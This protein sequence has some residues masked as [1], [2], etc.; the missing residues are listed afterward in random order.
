MNI[1]TKVLVVDDEPSI[2]KFLKAS[3]TMQDYQVLEA[4]TATE[5]LHI[6][7][8]ETP[9]LIVLD[10][11]LPD[12][13]G[14]TVLTTIRSWSQVPIIVLTVQD[15]EESKVTI[16][17]AGA[18][19]YLT[20]PFS[21]PELL[22]RLRVA[23]RHQEQ[24]EASPFFSSG[25]LNVDLA[26]YIVTLYNKEVH[27]TSTEFKI[28]KLLI[29]YAGR[30]VSHRQILKEIW[31]ANAVEQTQYIRVYMGHLRKKIEPKVD[32]IKLIITEPGIGY[33]LRVI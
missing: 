27:L 17:D 1:R 32:S 19:D 24:G 22:A 3:L 18:D 15:D 5:A 14:V 29:K 8:S 28:L 11:G 10:L 30:V 12:G 21:V 26:G 9:D 7:V 16:L 31:G 4:T 20:K 6:A 33:R 23:K 2:R 13:D 25:P